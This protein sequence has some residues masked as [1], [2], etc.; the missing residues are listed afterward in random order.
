M[1]K[2]LKYRRKYANEIHMIKVKVEKLCN[3]VRVGSALWVMG[4]V[5][6]DI[7]NSNILQC[8]YCFKDI[9]TVYTL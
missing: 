6:T 7:T 3:G 1:Y 9:T 8:F 4:D 2:P 5:K